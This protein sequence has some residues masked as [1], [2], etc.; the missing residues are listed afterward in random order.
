TVRQLADADM[1]DMGRGVFVRKITRAGQEMPMTW[2]TTI[3]RGDA[4]TLVGSKTD[5]ERVAKHFGYA[6]RVTD[7]TDMLFMGLGITLGAIIG[8]ITLRIGG[9]P[10]GLST[11][12]GALVAGLICG[13]LRSVNPTFGRIPGPALWV[14]NN[15]GLNTFIAVVG[16]TAGP[17]FVAGLQANGI[18]LF[19]SGIV[20]TTVPFIIMIY[21]GKYLFKMHPAIVLGACAGGRTTT[22]ALGAIEEA[23]QS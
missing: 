6:D 12:G 20:V 3:H 7:R 8:A 14:F 15:V 23:A 11:S 9:V 17:G 1:K 19:V 13:W 18:G 4:L 16:I 22:A 10:I 2:G 21:A 5:V